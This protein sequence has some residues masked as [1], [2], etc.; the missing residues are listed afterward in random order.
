MKKEFQASL[1]YLLMGAHFAQDSVN[2]D[3]LSEMFFE[4]AAEERQHGVKF[5]QYLRWRG[6]KDNSFLGR[7]VIRDA[8]KIIEVA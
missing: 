5:M 4:H 1:Q 2:L 6:D 3:G 7:E 8:E